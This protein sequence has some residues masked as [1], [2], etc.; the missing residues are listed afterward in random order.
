MTIRAVVFD[1]GGVLEITPPLGTAARWEQAWGLPAG[2]LDERLGHLWRAGEVGDI[3]YNDVLA[4]IADA[5]GKTP[6]QVEAF[7]AD[8]WTEY[9][10]T[11]NTELIEYF[12]GLRG[13]YKTGIISNSFVGA[14]ER[15]EEIYKFPEMTDDIVYSHEVGLTKP[16]PGIF[17][18][19][20]YRLGV[21]P[22][23]AVF[24][25]DVPGHVTAARNLGWHG[26]VHVDTARTIADLEMLLGS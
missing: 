10:G 17:E 7:M 2:A 4:G 21:R 12:A 3:T 23:E 6:Q 24:V 26:I 13:R 15:E 1:I 18:L 5:F 20:C 9:L 11:P 19:S 8:V 14:R 25:D 16:D 22:E